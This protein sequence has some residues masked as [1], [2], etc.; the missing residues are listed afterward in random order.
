MCIGRISSLALEMLVTVTHFMWTFGWWFVG[1][2]LYLPLANCKEGFS[3]CSILEPVGLTFMFASSV[4]YFYIARHVLNFMYK[5]ELPGGEELS[6]SFSAM[7][8]K[9]LPKSARQGQKAA[10]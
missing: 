4:L 6:K 7:I 1:H 10:K 3:G 8:N 5:R 9:N 2:L